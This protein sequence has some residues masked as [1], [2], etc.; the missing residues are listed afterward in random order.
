M[1]CRISFFRGLR[2]ELNIQFLPRI[3]QTKWKSVG[4]PIALLYSAAVND[5]QDSHLRTGVYCQ[6]AADLK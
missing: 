5:R 1:G 3:M 4:H 2:A 6:T